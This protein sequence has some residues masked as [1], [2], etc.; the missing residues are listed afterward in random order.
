MQS[1]FKKRVAENRVTSNVNSNYLI[2]RVF[3]SCYFCL[4]K[5]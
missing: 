5:L 4:K 3:I 1:K 2:I